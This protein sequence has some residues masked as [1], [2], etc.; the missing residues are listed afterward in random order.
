M[1]ENQKLKEG[2]K[3]LKEAINKIFS[4]KKE[5]AM[6]QPALQPYRNRQRFS[7]G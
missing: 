2:Y 1:S 4:P 6:L 7:R 5:K 3:K